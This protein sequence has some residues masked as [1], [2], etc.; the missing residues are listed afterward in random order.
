MP[1]QL[2]SVSRPRDGHARFGQRCM[3][4]PSGLTISVSQSGQCFGIRNCFVPGWCTPPAGPTICGITSPARWTMTMSPSRICLRLMS[5]SLCSVARV[6]VTPPTSTGSISAHGLSAPV[7][8]TRIRIFEQLRLRGHRRPLERARPARP[9]VQRAEAPLLVER[10]DL[11]HDPVDLVVELDPA[12]LP[13]DAGGGD[14]LDRLEPLG[15]G[16]RAE[17]AL[18]AATRASPNCVSNSTPSAVAGAVDPG[19]ERPVGGDRR[20]LLAERAGGGVARVRRELL[21]RPGQPL[22]QLAEAGERQVDLAA[23]LDH[24]RARRP[25]CAA[26]SP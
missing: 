17:A 19:G 8:P 18:G 21:A 16:V 5:S 7:R 14:V 10:V 22:V 2:I 15:V 24:R 20:V 11:D 3:T 25:A 9:R 12:L 26:G 4:S 1:V 13:R 23:H 6:T